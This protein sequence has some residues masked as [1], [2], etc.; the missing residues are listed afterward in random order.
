MITPFY[1]INYRDFTQTDSSSCARDRST[2]RLCDTFPR[3]D[4]DQG[5]ITDAYITLLQKNGSRSRSLLSRPN[6]VLLRLCS[7]LAVLLGVPVMQELNIY[8]HHVR[9]DARRH[10]CSRSDNAVTLVSGDIG[11]NS[12][13]MY[14]VEDLHGSRRLP[15]GVPHHVRSDRVL[16]RDVR[17]DDWS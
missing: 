5:S 3:L 9:S 2:R 4:C 1:R 16:R 6:G 11:K 7:M 8:S 17:H 14:R 10:N 13:S 12:E 15:R